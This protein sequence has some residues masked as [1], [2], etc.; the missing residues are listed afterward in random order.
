[1][2]PVPQAPT[3]PVAAAGLDIAK[4]ILV[5]VALGGVTFLLAKV[6]LAVESGVNSESRPERKSVYARLRIAARH[7][8][9]AERELVE[10]ALVFPED[11][12]SMSQNEMIGKEIRE[13]LKLTRQQF[14]L[15]MQQSSSSRE[16]VLLQNRGV[17]LFGPPG[18]GKTT[19]AKV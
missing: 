6:F 2:M 11:V 9:Q 8:T 12:V 15:C 13:V 3:G 5:T 1:M 4:Q 10:E 16:T 19:I 18:T 7:F 14:K 17:L